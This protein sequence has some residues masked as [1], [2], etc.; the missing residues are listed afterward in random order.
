MRSNPGVE[1]FL[2]LEVV[3]AIR[4]PGLLNLRSSSRAHLGALAVDTTL[5]A[6]RSV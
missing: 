2:G 6:R 4:G 5:F 1:Y 3:R